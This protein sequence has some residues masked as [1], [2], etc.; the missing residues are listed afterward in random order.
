MRVL[1]LQLKRIGDLV[2]TVPSLSALRRQYPKAHITLAVAEACAGLLPAIL[3]VDNALVYRS[4]SFNL[5]L[6]HSLIRGRFDLCL[7][8]TG[9]DRSALM[10]RLSGAETRIGFGWMRKN[11]LRGAAYTRLVDSSVRDR[12]TADHYMDLMSATV[13][14][15][16]TDGGLSGASPTDPPHERP[17]GQPTQTGPSALPGLTCPESARQDAAAI[18][19]PDPYVVIHPGSA[20]TEKYW[21]A[22]RWAQVIEHIQKSLGLK[23]VLTG[24]SDPFER[25]HLACIQ[26]ALLT[27]CT[28]LSGR[29]DLLGFA[30]LLENARAVLS[31]DTAAVHL[32]AE[33]QRPQLALF[34]VTNPFHWRPR[35]G[36]ALVLSASHPEEPLEQFSPRMKGAPMSAI[37]TQAVIRATDSLFHPTRP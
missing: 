33:F 29:I 19:G 36:R 6:W 11:R 27:P 30:A 3:S 22:E 8:Y 25:A 13:P 20:R 24:G 35:H 21:V 1:V 37:S 2:L 16:A 31:C 10:T 17:Q 23:C 12:H 5:P 14:S 26:S 9:T 4:N 32:A 18:A 15:P 34:G 7:D 28:D